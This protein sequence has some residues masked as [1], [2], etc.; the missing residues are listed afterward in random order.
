MKNILRINNY[1]LRNRYRKREETYGKQKVKNETK[2]W[3]KTL[4]ETSSIILEMKKEEN[5]KND[6]F[7]DDKLTKPF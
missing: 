3:T 4:V 7:N 2:V 1:I 6:R 5:Y